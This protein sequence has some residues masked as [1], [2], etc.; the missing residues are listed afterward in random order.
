MPSAQ[1][2]QSG[3]RALC[4]ATR[5]GSDPA[6]RPVALAI[7]HAWHTKHWASKRLHFGPHHLVILP[8]ICGLSGFTAALET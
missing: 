5:T 3:Y 1:S 4:W 2:N 8:T 7:F 6:N